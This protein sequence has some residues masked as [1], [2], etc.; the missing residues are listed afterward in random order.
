MNG[1]VRHQ[2]RV[3]FDSAR[4]LVGVAG[5]DAGLFAWYADQLAALLGPSCRRE[6]SVTRKELTTAPRD[7]TRDV[8]AG[9]WRARLEDVLRTRPDV[10]ESL[11][12]LTLSA[13]VRLPHAG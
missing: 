6:L 8:E 10:T 7:N 13:Q 9:K 1:V 11:H 3:A 2:P 4:V 5:G 12:Q